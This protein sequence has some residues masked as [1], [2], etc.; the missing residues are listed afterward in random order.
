MT[1]QWRYL[2]LAERDREYSPSSCLAD[3]DYRPFVQAYRDVGERAWSSLE[4]DAAVST[5]VVRYGDAPSQT[6]DVALPI[7]TGTG[8]PLV[9]YFHGGYW[10]E[11]SKRDSRFAAAHCVARG[12]GFAAVDYTLAPHAGLDEIVAEC[13]LAVRTLHAEAGSLGFDPDRIVVAGSSAGAHLAA[14]VALDPGSHKVRIDRAILVS[15]IY[16][17]EPLIGTSIDE[18]LG[19]DLATAR[20][21][22]PLLLNVDGFPPA[23]VAYGENETSEFKAQSAAFADRLAAA[24]TPVDTLEVPNRNHFDVI[25]DLATAD[26]VLGDAVAAL[27]ETGDAKDETR[28]EWDDVAEGWD[29]DAAVR[30]YA[31]AAHSSLVAL[32]DRVELAGARICD[33]GCGTGLLTE[34]LADT[35]ARIDAVD[36]SPAMLAVVRDKI[37]RHGWTHVRA[38]DHLPASDPPYGIVLCSSVLAFVEEPPAVLAELFDRLTPGG[39]LV[40]WDWE[41]DEADAEPMGFTVAEMA[42]A[43]RDAGF[44]QVEVGT[45]FEVAVGGHVM[46]PLMGHARRPA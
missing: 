11:L 45:A 37:D 2:S 25:L 40:Q 9:V 18:A 36:T 31:A 42:G 5:S 26:T 8:M 46:A 22:S 27:L 15:G 33:F 43:L 7:P 38:L 21:N 30:A 1:V 41:R 3:G 29:D 13:R 4:R 10:Q 20:R 34:L 14:M 28:S 35:A 44:E 24:G 19:L 16:E 23:L 32:A 17:L 12:W 6:I 39:W